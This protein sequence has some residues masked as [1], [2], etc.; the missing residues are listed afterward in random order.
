[1]CCIV[2]HACYK[3][4]TIDKKVASSRVSVNYIAFLLRL[5]L[6]SHSNYIGIVS[7][8]FLATSLF[9]ELKTVLLWHEMVPQKTSSRFE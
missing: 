9:P 3:T 6:D 2:G 8:I 4:E 5:M 7:T 1:M